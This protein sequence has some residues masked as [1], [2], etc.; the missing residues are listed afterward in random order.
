MQVTSTDDVT[1]ELHDLGGDG[2]TLLVAHATGF[3]AGAY[4]PLAARLGADFHVWAV[5]FRA[6]GDATVPSTGD[7]TW[8]G[9][10][11]DVLAV[12]GALDDGPLFA[13]GHSM[14]G[15]CLMGAEL[16]VPGTLRAAYLFEP[17]IVPP[18]FDAVAPGGNPLAESARRRRPSFPSRPEA[19]ARYAS[20]P[21]LG[22]F[23]AD[24]LSAYVEHGFADAPDGTITL[25]CTPEH[26]AQVF[27]ASGKPLISEMA[28]VATPT[29]VARGSRDRSPGPA[30]FADHIA[31]SLP[32]GTLRRYDHLGHFGPFQ[33]PDTIAED[34][35][36]A[37]LG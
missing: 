26:E 20:R 35:T 2:P 34:L 24:A 27:E 25:K 32:N 11:D 13:V 5:D 7:L 10:A 21:P 17:I 16:R 1:L 23:R 33:D 18:G 8:R 6:H 37:F 12:A 4:R 28:Q 15:A 29:V 31:A 3:C 22:A 14:G 36:A 30:D 19:L 9:M